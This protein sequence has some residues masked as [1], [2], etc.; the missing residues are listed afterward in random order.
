[1]A[2]DVYTIGAVDWRVPG[3]RCEFSISVL[4][5]VN[6]RTFGK[7]K[8][9]LFRP[10]VVWVR[11]ACYRLTLAACLVGTLP[12]LGRSAARNSSHGRLLM[13]FFFSSQPRRAMVTP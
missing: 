3:G 13:T 12:G 1:M 9:G 11:K 2:A 7:P 6:D 4:M 5:D 8:R 10:G